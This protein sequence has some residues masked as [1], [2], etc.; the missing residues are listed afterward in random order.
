MRAIPTTAN[1]L[2]RIKFE[3]HLGSATQKGA[4]SLTLSGHISHNLPWNQ[5]GKF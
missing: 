5:F 4:E 1:K 3:F 2:R